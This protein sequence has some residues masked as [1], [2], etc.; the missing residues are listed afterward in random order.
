MLKHL[1][2]N[3]NIVLVALGL[4]MASMSVLFFFLKDDQQGHH[5][6]KA[7]IVDS[8]SFKTHQEEE[9]L[10]RE[11]IHNEKDQV[12]VIGLDGLIK[13]VSW[14]F[15]AK[16]GYHGKDIKNTLFFSYLNPDD[17]SIFLE[18]FGKVIDSESALSMVGP[19]RIKD[20]KGQYHF[21]IGSLY[22]IIEHE[23]VV[24]I[25]I[26]TRDITE[27]LKKDSTTADPHNDPQQPIHTPINEEE[28]DPERKP[29]D[30]D[31]DK[32]IRDKKENDQ[33]HLMADKLAR[34]P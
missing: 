9:K 11:M 27:E 33:T 26:A 15:E 18:A 24:E 28:N 3:K 23:K 22:P 2:Q 30:K 5:E 29:S 14:D 20:H 31:K 32:K 10:Y 1:K 21:H 6:L 25:A 12:I 8:I 34:R 16:T 7:N 4:F 19:Y 17:L 13:F